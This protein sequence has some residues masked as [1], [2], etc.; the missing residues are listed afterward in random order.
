M[1]DIDKIL[2]A[3]DFVL[4]MPLKNDKIKSMFIAK[5]GYR[6]GVIIEG[7]QAEQLLKLYSL[8]SFTDKLIIGSFDFPYGRK[9]RNLLNSGVAAEEELIS[10]VILGAM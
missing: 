3:N 8:Y 1:E 5:L 6:R 4:V 9:L 7:S 10:D 2:N